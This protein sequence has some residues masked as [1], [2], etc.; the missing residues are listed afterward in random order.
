MMFSICWSADPVEIVGG[1][2]VGGGVVVGGGMVGGGVV[3][4]GGMVGGGEGRRCEGRQ[5]RWRRDL[6][7]TRLHERDPD[8]GD[9]AQPDDDPDDPSHPRT[10]SPAAS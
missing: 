9:R 5:C 6:R 4:E 7:P 8:R 2:M 3:V 1:G 10:S